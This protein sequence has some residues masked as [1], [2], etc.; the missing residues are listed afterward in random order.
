[1]ESTCSA[2]S[3]YVNGADYVLF[4]HQKQQ[5][6]LQVHHMKD[7]SLSQ[8]LPAGFHHP[9]FIVVQNESH[10]RRTNLQILIFETN[11]LQCVHA[12]HYPQMFDIFDDLMHLV[13]RPL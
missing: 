8:W 7:Y 12:Q 5:T 11:A 10:Q 9:Q 1:M 3:S 4:F 2:F 13:K 6:V